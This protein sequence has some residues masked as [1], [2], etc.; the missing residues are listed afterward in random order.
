MKLVEISPNA[1]SVCYKCLH[2]GKRIRSAAGS[3][4][5]AESIELW[6]ELVTW[7]EQYNQTAPGEPYQLSVEFQTPAAPLPFERTTR[8]PIPQAV[9]S[10]VWRRDSGQCVDCGTKHNLQFDHIIP[11][12]KGGASTVKNV[13]LLCQTCNSR[14][15]AKV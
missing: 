3:P 12:A 15:Q 7:A 5:A 13:Q 2:C 11:V 10:E 9:R 8:S 6:K 14:K 1:R 4:T